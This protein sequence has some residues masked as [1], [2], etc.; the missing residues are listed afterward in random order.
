[1]AHE[2]VMVTRLEDPIDFTVDDA[3]AVKKGQLMA[4]T[5]PRIAV[6]P[7]AGTDNIAGI[8]ARDKVALDSRVQ[9]GM[10]RRGIFRMYCSGTIT[11]GQPVSAFGEAPFDSGVIVAPLEASGAVIIGHMLEDATTGQSK[12]VFVNIGIG[13]RSVS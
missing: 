8:A 4:M 3:T 10:Y 7:T 9:L 13:G 5:T 6:A 12:E 1:M 2:A 11:I